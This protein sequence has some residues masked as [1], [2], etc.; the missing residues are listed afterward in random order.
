MRDR[1]GK[2]GFS[3]A[4]IGDLQ[5]LKQSSQA[6]ERQ[7]ARGGNNE[8]RSGESLSVLLSGDALLVTPGVAAP[9]PVVG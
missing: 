6:Q 7:N 4:G 9:P 2:R 5:P 3:N 1:N 8:N